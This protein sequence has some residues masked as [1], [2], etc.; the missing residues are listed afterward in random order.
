MARLKDIAIRSSDPLRLADMLE[1]VF[2]MTK[3]RYDEQKQSA[4]L[5]D[6]Y[7]YIAL[8]RDKPTGDHAR[9]AGELDHFG[10]YVDDIDETSTRAG[11][12]ELPEL[13]YSIPSVRFHEAI[14]GWHFEIRQDAGWDEMIQA[15]GTLFRLEPVPT[16]ADAARRVRVEPDTADVREQDGVTYLDVA[17]ADDLQVGG[18]LRVELGDDDAVLVLNVDGNLCA[19]QDSCPHLPRFG[20][21]SEGARQGAFVSCPVHGSRFDATSGGVLHPPAVRGLACYD[22]T[23][24]DGR[25]W[26]STAARERE[27]P[28]S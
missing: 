18:A 11:E 20:R 19:V 23:V 5:T 4:A 27:A 14:D 22:V 10:F 3:L 24:D 1:Q 25:V 26:V 9:Q 7:L 15:G 12:A 13:R 8:L 16:P 21:L 28:T 17:S 2:G 6:G